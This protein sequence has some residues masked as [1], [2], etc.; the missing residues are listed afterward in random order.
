MGGG[1]GGPPDQRAGRVARPSRVPCSGW[2]GVGVMLRVI[3]QRSRAGCS[4]Q[5][6]P[7]GQPHGGWGGERET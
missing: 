5:R 1:A 6:A 3:C 2:P 7:R 4:S